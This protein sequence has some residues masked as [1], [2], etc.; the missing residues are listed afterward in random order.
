M[1]ELDQVTIHQLGVP[2]LLLMERAAQGIVKECLALLTQPQK[3]T[4]VV[5]CG[6]GNNGGD[7]VDAARLL[8]NA[9]VTVS[10]Y[11]VGKREKMTEDTAAMEKMLRDAGGELL[12]FDPN[13]EEQQR[14]AAQADL[15]VDALFG[16]G[17]N[18]DIRGG[19][20]TAISWMNQSKA[21]V[22]A[23][24]IAS[25][26]HADSGRMLGCATQ[27]AVTVTFTLPKAGHY[28]GE[29]GL[30]TGR[31]VVH[32]IGIPQALVDGLETEVTVIDRELVASFLPQRPEDGHKGTFGKDF[33]LAG[34]VGY[35]GA[36]IL[37][38]KAAVR[39]GA[40]LVHLGVPESIYQIAAI[41]SDEAM[42]FPL[43][44]KDGKLSS[45]ALDPILDKMEGCNCALIGPG[46]G[47]S[48]AITLVV[49]DI[50]RTV[51]YPIVLDADGLNAAALHMD[52]VDQRRDCP[53][54]LTPHDGEFARMGGDLSDGD[55][56]TAAQMFAREHGCLLVLKGHRTIITLPNG[57]AFVNTT[58]NSGMAKGGSGDVLSG[59]ILGLV[60]QGIHPV[61]ATVAAVWLHGRAGDLAAQ[62][63]GTYA[64]TPTDLLDYLPQAFLEV[65]R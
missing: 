58:G 48:A 61:K 9:G 17:L 37:A 46:L 10:A 65:S 14:R 57:E 63:K 35:T 55:R 2:S 13:S 21:P 49:R 3:A 7:G 41:K 62:A 6:P 22:V 1:R 54:I 42:P 12:D 15:F 24:D 31:L 34:S 8:K 43:P 52:M 28:V 16:I 47:R 50:L 27:A 36:P 18:A 26:I 20:Q 45:E 59:I 60:G 19:A 38:S 33:I 4:A 64:M 44:E 11:L 29:G 32:E 53:T 25:G 5:Y 40:G 56:L 23:A 39:S 51:N 30:H